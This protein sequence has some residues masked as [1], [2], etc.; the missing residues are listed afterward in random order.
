[1]KYFQRI[2]LHTQGHSNVNKVF[3]MFKL[4]FDSA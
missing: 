2:V 1:M 4:K 3:Q